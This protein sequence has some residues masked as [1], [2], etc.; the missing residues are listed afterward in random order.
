MSIVLAIFLM[1]CLVLIFRQIVLIRE[2]RGLIARDQISTAALEVR[3]RRYNQLLRA[4]SDAI[5]VV[6]IDGR[7][8]ALNEQAQALIGYSAEEAIR[9][10]Y[11]QVY[12]IID[13]NSDNP[14][15]NTLRTGQVSERRSNLTLNRKDG[16]QVQ[17][18]EK[19]V[20]LLGDHGKVEGAMCLFRNMSER[21]VQEACLEQL[22]FRDS[23]TSLYNRAFFE[24]EL[25]RL[26]SAE[27]LPLSLMIGDLDGLK[28]TNDIFGHAA[29]DELLKTVARVFSE[30][31]RPNDRVFRWGGDEFVMLLPR[32]STEEAARI[33]DAVMAKL[34]G[35]SIG[36]I[37]LHM[38]LGWATKERV[39]QDIRVVWQQA[40]EQMYW[41]KTVDR[42]SFQRQTL[43]SISQELFSRSAAEKGHGERVGELAEQFG[44][45]LGLA[46]ADLGKLK[47]AG[48]LHDI[49]KVALEP[50][51]LHK[52][53]PL[54]PQDQHEMKRH[55][56]V[57]F[58]L[59][60]FFE[61]TADL[62]DGVLAHHEWW[63]GSGYPKGLQGEKIPLLGRIL[64]IMET[65]DRVSFNPFARPF[66]RE[67]A[68][69]LIAEGAGGKFDPNL[70]Q[71]FLEMMKVSDGIEVAVSKDE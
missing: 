1:A 44:A 12:T 61:D 27:Y 68:L 33:R 41:M 4:L 24:V 70:V 57:G 19:V 56:L 42:T 50:E 16:Q 69:Q 64:A 21:E 20:P 9:Q 17:I 13:P 63:D 38:T 35:K 11:E 62:A 37:K 23:L 6:D 58:R 2:N 26:D 36:P 49:G 10:P 15:T 30:V 3:Q 43:E 29:G 66:G 59:L 53:F 7:V 45:Y 51:I 22:T 54:E 52:P 71:S 40:D 65:Y 60:N 28:L 18:T 55:P 25:H 32:T 34:A 31:V 8:E 14:M 48:Y 39:E 47:M 67:E 5:I 46:E